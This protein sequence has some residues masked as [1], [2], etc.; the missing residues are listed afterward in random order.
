MFFGDEVTFL[1]FMRRKGKSEKRDENVTPKLKLLSRS[2]DQL[3]FFVE[4]SM[5][6]TYG[7][8][9]LIVMVYGT[10]FRRLKIL[11]HVRREEEEEIVIGK[12][13]YHDDPS[14]Q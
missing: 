7:I 5:G 6:E 2:Q 11:L 8:G 13:T 12:R 1:L 9:M 4:S 3:R 10:R 14:V